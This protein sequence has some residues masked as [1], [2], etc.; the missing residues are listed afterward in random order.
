MRKFW[1]ALRLSSRQLLDGGF[2]DRGSSLEDNI[3]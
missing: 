1:Q 2:E 3:S